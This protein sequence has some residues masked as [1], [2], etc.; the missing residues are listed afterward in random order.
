MNPNE[1]SMARRGGDDRYYN[2][3]AL[4]IRQPWVELIFQGRKRI[5]VRTWSDSY[6]GLVW[7]HA[8]LQTDVVAAEHLGMTGLFT[9]G[10][11]GIVSLVDIIPLDADRW[12]QW[13]EVH[14]VPGPAP[15]GAF[16]W[17]LADPVRLQ[18]PVVG[19]GQLKLF[20]IDPETEA[21]LL[22]VTPRPPDR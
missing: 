13:R 22:D 2:L 10:F 9:G 19:R 12:E 15:F 11:V 21:R 4:S 20:R 1:Q 16:A 5:E 8:G 17:M 6:R 14:C 7:L 18:K 3:P